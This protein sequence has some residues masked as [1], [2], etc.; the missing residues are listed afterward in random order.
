LGRMVGAA[1]EPTRGHVSDGGG[2]SANQAGLMVVGV[3]TVGRMAGAAD[4]PTCGRI[5]D[6]W[7]GGMGRRDNSGPA[8]T[9]RGEG[10]HFGPHGWCSL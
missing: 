6:G 5:R 10:G 4:E 2:V 1:D 7:A 9:R 8:R 3:P